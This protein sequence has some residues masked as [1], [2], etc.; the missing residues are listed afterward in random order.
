[1]C[2]VVWCYTGPIERAEETFAPV[3]SFGPPAFALLGPMPFPALQTFFDP[4]LP[5]GLQW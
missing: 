5:P 4:L 1:M 3:R 2:G